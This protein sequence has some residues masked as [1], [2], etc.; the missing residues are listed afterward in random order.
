MPS[1]KCC[2]PINYSLEF[3]CG[4]GLKSFFACIAE[5][6]CVSADRARLLCSSRHNTP[7]PLQ[8]IPQLLLILSLN[9]EK[10]TTAPI[11]CAASRHSRA[12]AAGV[13][14][15]KSQK[16]SAQRDGT[17]CHGAQTACTRQAVMPNGSAH[18][19]PERR[20]LKG[21]QSSS[22]HEYPVRDL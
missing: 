11:Q 22:G 16:L 17:V 8:L 3:D 2:R 7:G 14:C 12:A 21:I 5:A 10:I 6:A 13:A 4:L 18:S 20:V 1:W 15:V 19:C 9:P